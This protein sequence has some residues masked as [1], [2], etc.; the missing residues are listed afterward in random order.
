MEYKNENDLRFSV[1]V[2]G[3]TAMITQIILLRQFLVVFSGNELL[4][5]VILSNWMLLT[6][7][8]AAF[9]RRII[10]L[11][12]TETVY[13][14]AHIILGVLPLVTSFFI[15]YLKNKIFPP[16]ITYDILEIFTVS[17]VLLLPFCFVAGAMFTISATYI[18]KQYRTNKINTVYTIETIGSVV[19]GLLFNF[20]FIFIFN[21][22][23]SLKLIMIIN[24]LAAIIYGYKTLKQLQIKVLGLS[25]I[26]I[27]G[28]IMILNLNDTIW[29][30]V[31]Q[32]QDVIL[33]TNSPYG[34]IVITETAGQYNIYQNGVYMYSNNNM[35]ADE[36][37]VHYA[38]LQHP[39]PDNVLLLSGGLTGN[40]NEILKYNVQTVDY[41]E[42]DPTLVKLTATY[43]HSERRS[44]K[45]NIIN[46]DTRLYLKK[47][48]KTYDV[49]LIN[50][51]DPVTIQINR[52]FTL[53]FFEE[54]KSRLSTNG[55]VSLSLSS[56]VN[57][58]SQEDKQLHTALYSTLKLI[59]ENV[60]IIPGMK[61]YFIASDGYLSSDIGQLTLQKKIK[62]NYVNPI[63][64]D[65]E[66]ISQRREKIEKLIAEEVIINYDF[67]PVT[68]LYQ[69]KLW[70]SQSNFSIFLIGFIILISLFAVSRMNI[71]N[72]G[73]FSTGFS[74]SSLVVL[75][76]IA[77]QIIYGYVYF[78]IG[79]FFTVF[80]IGIL[81][82]TT[83][84]RKRFGISMKNYSLVQYV[85]G[86]FAVVT[87]LILI[88]IKS[89][90]P[91]NFVIHAVFIL[92]TFIIGILAGLQFS[93]A[94]VLRKQSISTT[95]SGIYGSDL[96][97]SAIG[98][99]LVSIVLI[100]Y[101][102]LIK[103]CL[104][105]GILNFLTGLLILYRS[106]KR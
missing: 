44:N 12:P 5:G 54:L 36:E 21:P 28:I 55:I 24:F 82:A 20:V 74:A 61:N 70:I 9:A 34:N 53:E 27:G 105:L 48:D 80:M 7:L 29:K 22:F 99:L 13:P 98:A 35:I 62:S 87:P 11:F 93:Q 75:L 84:I 73:I 33:H 10:K 43:M 60:I 3:L 19:G 66:L 78:M 39:D 56:S 58:L 63:Y 65:N 95:A 103:V 47:V 15:F 69:F 96:L 83:W 57:Y 101:F 77:F 38:M 104:I 42:I 97:G 72:F 59:F 90:Q 94:T 85:I 32:N 37:N 41:L 31:F 88:S 26:A 76:I 51:P 45:V 6:G 17:L 40:I 89:Q 81:T 25:V 68:F 49:A 102:G 2:V 30:I 52:Y 4:I 79:I 92:L 86:I 14:Y 106:A 50:L 64:L 91:L 71:V 100:P 67:F 16:G 18:S 46:Q 23:F 8:G 1:F